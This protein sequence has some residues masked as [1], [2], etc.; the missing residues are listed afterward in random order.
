MPNDGCVTENSDDA[1]LF[2]FLGGFLNGFMGFIK[3]F[4]FIAC[5]YRSAICAFCAFGL[6]KERTYVRGI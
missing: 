1:F 5:L 4:A 3:L 6:S 2:L